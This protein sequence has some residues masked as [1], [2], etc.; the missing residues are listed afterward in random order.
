MLEKKCGLRRREPS[1]PD[2]IATSSG[3]EV[4]AI[5]RGAARRGA[6]A[7]ECFACALI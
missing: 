5:R 4:E 7:D 3:G 6:A 2:R 1:S